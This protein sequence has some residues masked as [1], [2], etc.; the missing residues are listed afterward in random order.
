MSL[1][2]LSFFN[3]AFSV[4]CSRTFALLILGKKG[5][6]FGF[7]VVGCN[8]GVYH[9]WFFSLLFFVGMLG[10]ILECVLR[11]RKDKWVECVFVLLLFLTGWVCE[12]G[13]SVL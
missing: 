2:F 7:C 1:V 10:G 4:V 3:N 12:G 9:R 6:S 13:S 11:I 8:M 5:K